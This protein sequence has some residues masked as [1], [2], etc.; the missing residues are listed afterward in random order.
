AL[1]GDGTL[2]AWGD[3][4]YNQTVVNPAVT[5][6]FGVEGGGYH[7]L[8]IKGSGAP[9]I[10]VQP[11]SK[12][13]FTDKDATLQVTAVGAQPLTY[14]WQKDG[15]SIPGATNAALSLRAVTLDDAGA[16]SVF[17]ANNL[18]FVFSDAAILSPVGG[19]PFVTVP[20]RT[21]DAFCG[22]SAS[23]QVAVDGSG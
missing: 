21:Q 20:P 19:P 18:G 2:A 17:V 1:K 4:T 5:G 22:E 14:Q 10:I 8:A 13:V 6:F 16:Y 11:A 15:I 3:N 23:L 7:S 9:A 12:L